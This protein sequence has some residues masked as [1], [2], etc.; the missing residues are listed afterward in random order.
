MFSSFDTESPFVLVR[1]PY[2]HTAVRLTAASLHEYA[3]LTDVGDSESGFIVAPFIA[4]NEHP[5]YM[6]TDLTESV[7]EY[8]DFCKQDRVVS[9]EIS[10]ADDRKA[11]ADSFAKVKATIDTGQCRK[12]VLSRR[13]TADS[14]SM[15]A[16][17]VFAAACNKYPRC[18]V[19]LVNIP[20]QGMWLTA[21]P[22]LLYSQQQ[23]EAKTMA[24]AG[25]MSW[26]EVEEGVVWSPKNM[27]EQRLVVD[28][29]TDRLDEHHITYHV[30]S[31]RTIRT[32][33]LA[34]L[35]S[36]IDIRLSDSQSAMQL[37][38]M[39]HPTPA[40]AGIPLNNAL[41]VI[42]DS[43]K[44]NTRGYYAGFTGFV[45]DCVRGTQCYVSLR[46][47]HYAHDRKL[48]LHAGGGIV[49]DSE[50]ESEWNETEL[51]LLTM[52]SVVK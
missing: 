37:L 15:D 50:E 2:A 11:Y 6:L 7:F 3:A 38:R 9:G 33:H 23:N 19:A 22:E 42:S 26:H 18:Y 14:V 49:A 32:G 36:E 28:Y 35:C 20:R 45:N 39:L 1:L 41:A 27:I 51:K 46:L 43:E 30:D 34:H 52:K 21:T 17:A 24:L 4:D 8:E 40:V 13:V 10:F 5:V 48:T 44:G 31:P 16:V 47:L 12:V 29:I 25:T